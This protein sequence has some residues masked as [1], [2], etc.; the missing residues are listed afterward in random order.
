LSLLFHKRAIEQAI[1]HELS[2]SEESRLRSHLARC[3]SCRHYYDSLTV[4]ARLL[5][6]GLEVTRTEEQREW[7]LLTAALDAPELGAQWAQGPRARWRWAAV[8]AVPAVALLLAAVWV[9]PQLWSRQR[10]RVT[11]R[12][13][14]RRAESQAEVLVYAQKKQE[15]P[16]GPVRLVADLPG[17]GEGQLSRDE[18]VQFTIHHRLPYDAYVA[19][20]GVDE[21]GAVHTYAPQPGSVAVSIPATG[22]G[23]SLAPSVDLSVSHRPGLMRL[24]AVFSPQPLSPQE[25]EQAA[26]ETGKDLRISKRLAIPGA[27]EQVTGLFLIADR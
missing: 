6:G 14:E 18:Y 27:V 7:M 11:F 16:K 20:V 23:K 4:G 26:K 12:G 9:G 10:P 22:A 17:S 15:G 5:R 13:F 24:Y 1:N 21:S 8:L 19:L 25:V 2:S 3:A